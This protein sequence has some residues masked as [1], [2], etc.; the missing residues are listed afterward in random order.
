MPLKIS[1][2]DLAETQ[3]D[4]PNSEGFDY[5]NNIFSKTMSNVLFQE[6]KR[7]GILAMMEQIVYELI[8]QVKCIKLTYGYTSK[9][10]YRKFN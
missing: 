10:K 1:Y 6:Q 2:Y 4:G 9:K 7:T 3:Q 5:Q 8:Q